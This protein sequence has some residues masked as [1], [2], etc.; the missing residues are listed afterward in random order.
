MENTEITSEKRIKV[1]IW[2]LIFA[3][4]FLI[5]H[6]AVVMSILPTAFLEANIAHAPAR[7]FPSQKWI[8]LRNLIE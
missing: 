4:S 1:A 3:F 2:V 6:L 8:E 7:E 5:Y